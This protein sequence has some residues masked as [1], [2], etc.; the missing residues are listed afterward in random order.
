MGS[1]G[2]PIVDQA[3]DGDGLAETGAAPVIVGSETGKER[4]DADPT[5]HPRSIRAPPRRARERNPADEG[6]Q[7]MRPRKFTPP[8]ER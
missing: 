2:V 5:A 1:P 4:D 8:G 7:E 3:L 6:G